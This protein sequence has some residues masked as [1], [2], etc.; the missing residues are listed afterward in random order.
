MCGIAVEFFSLQHVVIPGLFILQFE[1][2]DLIARRIAGKVIDGPHT[3]VHFGSASLSVSSRVL[4]FYGA[5][6]KVECLEFS[7]V[8]EQR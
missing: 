4:P 1:V 2:R 8:A 3:T 6:R 7:L 5:F